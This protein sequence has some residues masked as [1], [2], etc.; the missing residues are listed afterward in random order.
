MDYW[1]YAYKQD[2]IVAGLIM[3]SGSA[4]SF[5]LNSVEHT[6]AAWRAVVRAVG[7]VGLDEIYCM[8]QKDWEDIR[9]AAAE[10]KPDSSMNKNPLRSTPAF[11]PVVDNETV[12]D[13]YP[14]L[15]KKGLFAK[16]VSYSLQLISMYLD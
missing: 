3:Q 5:P 4:L 6:T 16:L 1:A 9:T 11:Y 10:V 14:A 2:P 8:Q 13:N 12:F 7:C 15:N